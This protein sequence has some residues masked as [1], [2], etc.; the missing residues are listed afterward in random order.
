M[1]PKALSTSEIETL[2]SKGIAPAL[3]SGSRTLVI[4]PDATRSAPIPAAF[5]AINRLAVE[6]NCHVD[7]L[8]A[9]GTHPPMTASEI[10]SLVGMPLEQV[11]SRLSRYG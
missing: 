9:L 1:S 6:K 10:A 5:S 2:V 11:Q 3:S 7:F 8:I 4:I